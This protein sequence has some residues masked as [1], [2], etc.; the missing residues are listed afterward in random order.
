VSV[1]S[2]VLCH[3]LALRLPSC[4]FLFCTKK[5]IHAS[6]GTNRVA[7]LRSRS[8]D[9]SQTNL[10]LRLTSLK[11]RKG[12]RF[13]DGSCLHLAS[14]L[15]LAG[16]ALQSLVPRTNALSI[17]PQGLRTAA[18]SLLRPRASGGATLALYVRLQLDQAGPLS[19]AIQRRETRRANSAKSAKH[20]RRHAW[21]GPL[22]CFFCAGG[23]LGHPALE[24][25][26]R[27][28]ACGIGELQKRHR[29][30]IRKPRSQLQAA[31]R[32]RCVPL[33][34]R[35]A[36]TVASARARSRPRRW[37]GGQKQIPS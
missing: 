3:S 34:A 22:L 6:Q 17:R 26:A 24:M 14:V 2:W 28:A 20:G 32:S 9:E 7:P 5:R 31:A 13:S 1:V 23:C 18:A 25:R 29:G 4:V 36:L 37:P 12:M 11:R 15:T 30:R 21:G 8:S 19:S 33:Q 35:T 27:V 10:M 16:L